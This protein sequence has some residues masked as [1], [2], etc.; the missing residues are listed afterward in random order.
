MRFEPHRPAGGCSFC[1]RHDCGADP[2]H[3]DEPERWAVAEKD[4]W[5]G[6]PIV[7]GKRCA[8][9]MAQGCGLRIDRGPAPERVEVRPPTDAEIG[10]WVRGNLIGLDPLCEALHLPGQP[11]ARELETDGR[12]AGAADAAAGP[13]DAPAAD[14]GP[15][16]SAGRARRSGTRGGKRAARTR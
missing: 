12:D 13:S 3:P 1:G 2:N 8:E 14:R 5:D 16:A 10:A 7:V 15:R 11:E 4:D 9:M 6:R